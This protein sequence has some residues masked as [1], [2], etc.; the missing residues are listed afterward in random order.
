MHPSVISKIFSHLIKMGF[1]ELRELEETL[2][3]IV[4]DLGKSYKPRR[5]ICS[6]SLI[7]ER[8]TNHEGIFVVYHKALLRTYC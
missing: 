8:A 2:A 7:L 3:L 1:T 4:A 6:L 5:N